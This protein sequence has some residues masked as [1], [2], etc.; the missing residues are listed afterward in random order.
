MKKALTFVAIA[1]L[2]VPLAVTV[3]SAISTSTLTAQAATTKKTY[4]I[5]STQTLQEKAAYYTGKK[6]VTTY[7]AAASADQAKLT[8]TKKGSL[9]ANK[10][11]YVTKEVAV[12]NSAGTQLVYSY[13]KGAG[14]VLT[15]DIHAAVNYN[16]TNLKKFSPTKTYHL[17]KTTTV[18]KDDTTT[19]DAPAVLLTVNGQLKAKKNVQVTK[20]ATLATNK[21]KHAYSYVKGY[22]WVLSSSL[23]SGKAAKSVTYTASK[24]QTYKHAKAYYTKSTKPVVYKATTAAD[25]P[26]MTLTAKGHLKAHHN[27]Q[28]TK[29]VTLA[30]KKTKK[31]VYSYVKGQG[32]VLKSSLHAG[33]TT[34]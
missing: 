11:Y 21:T 33:K 14:W 25:A 4:T 22:G 3:P 18:Y 12:K 16:I 10:T 29:Q 19:A 27:Y 9:K 31:H 32:W 7:S 24:A 1:A 8:L 30:T 17:T 23:K 28:V 26:K 6:A 34:K 15:T 13:V 2:A 20:T 5:V